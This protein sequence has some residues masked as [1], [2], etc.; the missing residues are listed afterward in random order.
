MISWKVGFEIELLAP[1]GRTRADLADRVARRGRGRVRRFFHQ[2]AEP[3]K[4][5]GLPVF[6][7]L[8]LGFEAIDSVGQ[9]IA[10][11]VDDLTLQRDLN[12]IAAPRAGWYRIVADD[13]RLLRLVERHCDAS[14]PLE[15][16]LLPLAALFGAAPQVHPSG[17]I[18]IVDDR[19][20]S[21][22]IGAPMPGERERPCE[23]VTAPL[24]SDHE[25]ILESLLE[26]ARS[27]AFSVP[28]E[29]A[30]HIHFDAD[31]LLSAPT[32]SRLVDTLWT[33]GNALRHLLGA[34]PNCVRLGRWPEALPA[35]VRTDLFRSMDWPAALAALTNVGLTKYCDFNLLN[36][37]ANNRAKHTFEVRILPAHLTAAPIVEATALFEALLRWCCEPR[38]EGKCAPATLPHLIQVLPIAADARRLWLERA[39]RLQQGG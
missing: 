9:R 7:N 16:V 22:A 4:A 39:A 34:N 29:G 17:M 20:A 11:F 8:T 24:E 35:L 36:I 23:I 10:A 27:E 5:P 21:V 6:E 25:A 32:L 38:N 19:G 33:H 12:R 14:A 2:Q 15:T 13:A 30:T 37:V 26:D 18:R 31:A 3:S 1:A 28:I